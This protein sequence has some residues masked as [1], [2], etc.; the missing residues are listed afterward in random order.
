MFFNKN[1]KHLRVLHGM[2]QKELAE[3]IGVSRKNISAYE[4]GSEARYD[5]L[6]KI[7]NY[8]N[9]AIDDLMNKDLAAEAIEKSATKKEV[10][11]ALKGAKMRVLSITVDQDNKENVELVPQKAA[12]G[13][14]AGFSDPEYLKE[15]PKY[16]LPFL[17]DSKTYRAFEITGDSMLPLQS[18]SVVVGELMMDWSNIK[19]GTV[20]VL[21]TDEGI[22]LKKVYSQAKDKGIFLLKSTNPLYPHYEVPINEVHEIWKYAAHVGREF[23]EPEQQ[24]GLRETIEQLKD[25]LYKIRLK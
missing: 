8:F 2:T 19:D 25:D 17:S 11:E 4:Q 3:R 12:A 20:C 21:V 16:Q 6:I 18:G 22:V 9:I 15:L 10:E 5:T 13:Y 14:T 24:D 1:S 7:A 23:P